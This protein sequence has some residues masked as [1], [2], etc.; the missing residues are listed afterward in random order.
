[1]TQ[2][3]KSYRLTFNGNDVLQL[4][5]LAQAFNK[6]SVTELLHYIVKTGL[7]HGSPLPLGVTAA[8]AESTSKATNTDDNDNDKFDEPIIV[9][10]NGSNGNRR[11]YVMRDGYAYPVH[12]GKSGTRMCLV[13]DKV[14][15]HEVESADPDQW[16]DVTH[17]LS[18]FENMLLDAWVYGFKWMYPNYLHML[19]KVK[20]PTIKDY[21]RLLKNYLMVKE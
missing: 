18:E 12:R 9:T 10:S 7:D 8:V 20:R 14:V 6:K 19:N 5:I 11:T 16:R 15:K 2:N 17:E 21:E 1:M 4:E 13:D 3:K